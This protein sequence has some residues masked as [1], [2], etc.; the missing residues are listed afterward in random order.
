MS[1]CNTELILNGS[2]GESTL[3]FHLPLKEIYHLNPLTMQAIRMIT[4]K[5]KQVLALHY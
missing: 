5:K 3:E 2:K 1:Y 4:Q